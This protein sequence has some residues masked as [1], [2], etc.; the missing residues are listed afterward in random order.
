MPPEQA[1]ENLLYYENL[2]ASEIARR[3]GLSQA[4]VSRTMG[5]LPVLKV[6]K[7]R[8]TVFVLLDEPQQGYPLYAVNEAG[9]PDLLGTLFVQPNNRTLVKTGSDFFV[10]DDIPYFLQ[11]VL[12]SG[13]LGRLLGERLGETIEVG[14]SPEKWSSEECLKFL[15]QHGCDLPGNLIVGKVSAERFIR[16]LGEHPQVSPADYDSMTNSINEGYYGYSSVAGEQPKF[17]A[18]TQNDEAGAF[19]AI[20]KYSGKIE[21]RSEASVRYQDLLIAEHV[22]HNTLRANGI[23]ASSSRI[24]RS[25]RVYLEVRRFDRVGQSG[26]VGVVDLMNVDAEC[27]KRADTWNDAADELFNKGLIDAE[28]RD[29]I[30]LRYAFGVLIGNIDM[31][32]GNLSFFFQDLKLGDLAPVYDMLPMMYMPV[33]GEIIPRDFAAKP[34][35]DVPEDILSSAYELALD[36]WQNV[37]NEGLISR[38]FQGIAAK[39][40]Q[41]LRDNMGLYCSDK[42]AVET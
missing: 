19:H 35:L 42:A 3:T 6:G 37:I 25:E 23:A 5:K 31:H 30:K 2:S 22:A 1:V 10:Y 16:Q 39:H 36:Y 4:T 38:S 29:E 12:P 21:V 26:R 40:L 27:L 14:K 24:I 9:K 34:I 11:S 41:T 17:T 18:L 28:C 32:F 20:V 33:R 8:N 13:F 15:V 7:A